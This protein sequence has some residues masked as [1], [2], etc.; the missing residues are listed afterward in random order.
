MLASSI[1]KWKIG[2]E[3][4]A[5][6]VDPTIP[7]GSPTMHVYIPKIQPMIPR[8]A[9]TITQVPLQNTCFINDPA[10][11]PSVSSTISTQNYKTVQRNNNDWFA[12]NTLNSGAQLKLEVLN[13]NVDQMFVTNKIDK[14]S[15]EKWFPYSHQ[16]LKKFS[17]DMTD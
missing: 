11:K 5:F 1:E 8:G 7:S 4:I 10:C 13:N 2:D 14:S 12:N 16:D 9:P 17:G 15:G 3:E 6:L